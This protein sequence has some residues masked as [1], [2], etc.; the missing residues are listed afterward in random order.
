M[1]PALSMPRCSWAI[2]VRLLVLLFVLAAV[3][4]VARWGT[5]WSVPHAAATDAAYTLLFTWDGA[6]APGGSFDRPIGVAVAPSGDVYVTDARQRVVHLT[7]SGEVLGEWGREGEGFGEFSNPIG[8]AIGP[9]GAVY[10]SDY[11]QDRVQKFTAAGGF[12]TAFG[13][14]GSGPGEFNGPA[15][16]AV[17]EAGSIYVTDFY[18]HR[19]QRFRADGSFDGVIGQPGRVGAGALHYPT[20][21]AITTDR[22]VIVADAYNYQVQWFDPRGVPLRRAGYHLLWIWPWP[23]TSTAGF[24]VPTDAAVGPNNAIHVADSGNRRVVMLSS[25]GAYLTE[26]RVP[27]A[28]PAVYSPEH[29]AVSRDGTMVY[30]TDLGRDRLLVLR[31]TMPRD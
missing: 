20:G 5:R 29:L 1:R 8:L 10:V 9:D 21:V 3:V 19:V 17:D 25:E 22:V 30:A 28:D 23:V 27:D 13:G 2:C 18:N 14:S 31:A 6:T 12:L 24:S 26:W 11:E 15:G 16:L 7:P 4:A